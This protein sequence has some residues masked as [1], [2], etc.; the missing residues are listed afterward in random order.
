MQ[1]G[2]PQ[3]N[4]R[5]RKGKRRLPPR[6]G[7]SRPRGAR[8]LRGDR[9]AAERSLAVTG[10]VQPRACASMPHVRV[11]YAQVRGGLVNWAD[12]PGSPQHDECTHA[13]W[14]GRGGVVGCCTLRLPGFFFGSDWQ[15]VFRGPAPRRGMGCG[16]LQKRLGAWHS[17]H[18]TFS[19]GCWRAQ[20]GVRI[21]VQGATKGGP[22]VGTD[23]ARAGPAGP[24]QE[25]QIKQCTQ[26]WSRRWCG[27][28]Q[29]GPWPR[30]CYDLRQDMQ[31][32]GWHDGNAA[33]QAAADS[34]Q[35]GS[36]VSGGR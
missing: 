34:K 11:L 5:V 14:P 13:S 24:V 3:R 10:E 16:G 31:R 8:P 17:A 35:A 26:C 15:P 30:G 18:I 2:A 25:A 9:S 27:V 28:F 20:W 33:A 36:P 19:P 32:G 7:R 29:R 22:I 4:K 1:G 23:R 21:R 12:I 6:L